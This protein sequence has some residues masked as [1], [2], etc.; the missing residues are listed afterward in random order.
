MMSK[1]HGWMPLWIGDYLG[2]TMHLSGAEHGAYLLLLM[3]SWRNGPLPDDDQQL[4]AIARTEPKAWRAMASTIRAFFTAS[5]AGLV[6]ARLEHERVSAAEHSSR[7]TERARRAAGARW[8]KQCSENAPS[9]AP[10]MPG[11][12]LGECPTQSQSP[13]SPSEKNSPSLRS[14]GHAA[15]ARGCR[16]P[17]A[18]VPAPTDEAF[19]TGL[20]LDVGRVTETFRD[21]WQ[22]QPGQ[23][24]VKTD[25]AATWRNWCRRDA[26]KR[27][28]RQG[29]PAGGASKLAWM[30]DNEVAG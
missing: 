12:V 8:A 29:D 30:F 19:A 9:T 10:S 26:E 25:W 27:P 4:A 28:G 14:G 23:K 22:A 20:G 13:S 21:Y 18:W 2:D 5:D 16:L 17:N 11:A 7:N 6:Q 3:H 1:T 15:V 24:G